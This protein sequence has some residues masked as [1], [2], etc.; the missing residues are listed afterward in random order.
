MISNE[1]VNIAVVINFELMRRNISEDV[2]ALMFARE[3]LLSI[4]GR[5]K[6][7][8][9]MICKS[10]SVQISFQSFSVRHMISLS[11]AV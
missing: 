4:N 9:Y 5:I 7:K 8:F 3:T 1:L 10:N 2:I 6:P 11:H